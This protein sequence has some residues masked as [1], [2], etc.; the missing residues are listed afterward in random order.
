[1]SVE[2]DLIQPGIYHRGGRWLVPDS[3]EGR[4]AL[5][6]RALVGPSATITSVAGDAHAA[7]RQRAAV[8]ARFPTAGDNVHVL[9]APL[10]APPD[11]PDLHDLDGILLAD[12]LNHVPLQRHQAIVTTLAARLHSGGIFMLVE[13]ERHGAS[14][15]IRNP[16]DYESFSYLAENAGLR[17]VRRVAVVPTGLFRSM[18]SALAVHP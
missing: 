12:A 9:S 6:L 18:Y 16:V 8:A 3:S 10:D 1:M 11:L 17:D 4:F 2:S 7:D 15:R 14:L 5:A 13:H